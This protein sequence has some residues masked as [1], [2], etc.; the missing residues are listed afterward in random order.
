M[1][2]S[3][4]SAD[5]GDLDSLTSIAEEV[6]MMHVKALPQVFRAPG[7]GSAWQESLMRGTEDEN[8]G[9]LVAELDREIV[10]FVQIDYRAA[11]NNPMLLNRHYAWID[12]IGVK[13]E[14]RGRGIGK[15]LMEAASSWARD[16]GADQIELNVWEFNQR[17]ISF[18]EELGYKTASR[19]MWK[20]LE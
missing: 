9:I 1:E 18:Y 16:M 13:S 10:G 19:R 17:A 7:D 4:R 6:G 5:A 15:A 20:T 12:Q 3:I 14:Y 2:L 8:A 11:P